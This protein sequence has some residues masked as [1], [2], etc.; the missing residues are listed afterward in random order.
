MGKAIASL[1]A[2]EG[3]SVLA[4]ARNA[5]ALAAAHADVRADVRAITCFPQDVAG[6]AL[7]GVD[8]LVNA[9][10]IFEIAAVDIM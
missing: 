5:Q 9:A 4:I 10:G 7:G 2:T 6:E 1:F 8:I 3:A